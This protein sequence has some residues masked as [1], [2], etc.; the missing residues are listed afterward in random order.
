MSLMNNQIQNI[1][2]EFT[3]VLRDLTSRFNTTKSENTYFQTMEHIMKNG[4]IQRQPIN[5]LNMDREQSQESNHNV[6]EY[7]YPCQNQ[8]SRDNTSK[9]SSHLQEI[10]SKYKK[11]ERKSSHQMRHSLD[12]TNSKSKSF[13]K[14]NS[15]NTLMK[16]NYD[17]L[18]NVIE[19]GKENIAVN[20]DTSQNYKTNEESFFKEP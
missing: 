6:S 14:S 2:N 15:T 13:N 19:V 5:N 7:D 18:Q 8:T 11:N 12:Y 1:R 3:T 16:N 20:Y 17:F 4:S 10:Y 9:D